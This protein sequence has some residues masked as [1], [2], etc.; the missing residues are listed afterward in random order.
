MLATISDSAREW[1]LAHWEEMQQE[2][3]RPLT[4]RELAGF[5][6]EAVVKETLEERLL[7][8]VHGPKYGIDLIVEHHHRLE[9]K[10]Q[11]S[12]FPW[13][14]SF[15]AWAPGWKPDAQDFLFFNYM[16]IHDHSVESVL[17]CDTL[18]LRGW[19]PEADTHRWPVLARGSDTPKKEHDV[20]TCDVL[21][22][23]DAEL[24]PIEEFRP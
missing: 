15:H 21:Q 17:V 9:V 11:V 7:H 16:W 1:G 4:H 20:L 22:I 2:K 18:R 12:P 6:G 23:P 24:R 13:R 14:P 19:Y 5:I 3:G 8:V 10:T